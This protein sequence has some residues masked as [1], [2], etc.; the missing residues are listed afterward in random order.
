MIAN[1]NILRIFQLF[2]LPI[3]A[4]DCFYNFCRALAI[5]GLLGITRIQ[6]SEKIVQNNSV[7]SLTGLHLSLGLMCILCTLILQFPST[8]TDNLR[9][10]HPKGVMRDR[11]ASCLYKPAVWTPQCGLHSVEVHSRIPGKYDPDTR[12]T[13]QRTCFCFTVL[14]AGIFFTLSF[15]YFTVLYCKMYKLIICTS[16]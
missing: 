3:K 8:K 4:W 15:Y 12:S 13:V 14:C 10:L 2:A 11:G 9:H 1:S 7:Q 16:H 5:T 6:W